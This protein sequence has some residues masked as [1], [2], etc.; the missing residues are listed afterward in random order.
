MGFESEVH[1]APHEQQIHIN[2]LELLAAHLAV[3]CFAIDKTNLTMYLKMDS[4][5]ALTYIN[6]LGGTIS[7]QLNC[8]AKTHQLPSY[9]SWRPDP[10]AMTTDAF[11]MDWAHVRGYANPPWSLIRRVLT[12]TQQKQAELVLVAPVWKAQVWYP[13][14]L[15]ML[16][17][18]PLLIPQRE[19]LIQPTHPVTLPEVMPQLA[20][21]VISGK[22][23]KTARFQ[24]RLQSFSWH[25][26]GRSPP[27][28]MTHSSG[29]GLA[30]VVKGVQIPFHIL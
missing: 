12:Q 30:G 21:W 4:M 14:L 24:K 6:K 11:T 20:M 16:V 27:R 2:I 17:E 23:T 9:A 1:G 19:D 18:I 22:Y 13:V 25:H 3:K 29:S 15:D 28:H 26:G 5:S 8:L 10:M 7:P